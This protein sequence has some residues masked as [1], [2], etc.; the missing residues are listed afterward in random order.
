MRPFPR[1][2]A[3]VLAFVL[4]CV[5]PALAA[6]P[7]PLAGPYRLKGFARTRPRAVAAQEPATVFVVAKSVDAAFEK[8]VLALGGSVVTTLPESG[9]ALVHVAPAG[10]DALRKLPGVLAAGATLDEAQGALLPEDV[11]PLAAA[12][13]AA[14]RA[15]LAGGSP[16]PDGRPLD[17][18]A[19]EPPPAWE[20]VPRMEELQRTLQKSAPAD[21]A[22]AP[23]RPAGATASMTS[24]YIAGKVSINMFIM[25]STGAA[26]VENWNATTDAQMVSE[27]LL[28]TDALK[29]LYPGSQLQF[30]VH[31]VYG[32]TD[33]RAQ[34]DCE[35]IQHAARS[36]DGSGCYEDAWVQQIL[37]KMG[38]SAGDMWTASRTY[39]DATRVAD[40][41][42]WAL[43]VFVANS[44][45]DTDGMFSDGRFGYA[46]LGGPHIIVTSDN[47][48]WGPTR[49]HNVLQHEMHHIFYVLD[50]YSSSACTCAARA[51]YFNGANDNCQ[52]SCI[53]NVTCVMINNVESSCAATRLQG[54][55]VDSNAD[56][57]PDV[58]AAAP[59]VTASIQ[60][61]ATCLAPVRVAGTAQVG[62]VA[63]LNPYWG[64]SG[65]AVSILRLTGV[66]Y[67]ADAGAWTAGVAVASDGAFDS[68]LENY[69][70]DVPLSTGVHAVD[71]RAVDTRSN[72]SSTLG[73]VSVTVPGGAVPPVLTLG[74]SGTN[75]VLSWGA[76]SGATKYRVR[77]TSS[78]VTVAAS[79]PVV[80]QAGTTWSN[81][82]AGN[83]FFLVA[84]VD[85]CNV[86]F[87]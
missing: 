58:L 62:Y 52:A 17:H 16:L 12:W 81:A 14:K 48:G 23:A 41:T 35:P 44:L 67:R 32:R 10:A 56:G 4:P 25:E 36:N 18:D 64:G 5:T 68:Y 22:A 69:T 53:S 83:A 50:E 40:K 28:A 51:G 9:I 8:A 79:A 85:A 66:E 82:P 47:D 24:E 76:A 26:S 60:T 31:A 78:P 74:K 39:A 19:L 80:E 7:E 34:V 57:T 63:N 37:T 42:D 54:G 84:S 59:T 55:T 49:M 20:A 86:E 61:A 33:T 29:R 3:L 6:R 21:K 1:A 27:L 46:W 73:H 15:A 77:R 13:G 45:L 2:A 43:N 38:T 75:V 71:V 87:P 70:V 72:R 30:T 11:K 65:P